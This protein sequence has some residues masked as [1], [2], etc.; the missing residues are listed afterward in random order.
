[1]SEKGDRMSRPGA[2]DNAAP[3]PYVV[4]TPAHNESA[5]IPGLIDCL[6]SQSWR[7]LRWLIVDDASTDGTADLVR[8]AQTRSPWIELL[9]LRR[10]GDRHFGGK[11]L[12]F[13]A[14]MEALRHLPYA[15]IA[16]LDADVTFPPDYFA[17]LR[18][19]LE[20]DP[21]LGLVG[22]PFSEDG[23]EMYDYRFT[24][25]DHVSGACQLF[26]RRCLEEMGGYTPIPGG[27]VDWVASTTA[28][29]LGWKTRTCHDRVLIHHRRMGTGNRGWGNLQLRQGRK[30]YLLGNEPLWQLVRC[31]YQAGRRPYVVGALLMMLGYT[32]NA[33]L[34]KPRPI[35]DRL[36][37]FVREEHRARLRQTA[38]RLLGGS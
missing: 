9:E 35:S 33:V 36:V 20:S 14:G 6:A 7:P 11:A 24:N 22:T 17:Y 10:E 27:G 18:G 5:T 16:N 29:M 32:E 8:A 12:G 3:R 21:R 25:P 26:R 34:R 1:M 23:T 38:R 30:D 4:I 31:L 37:R 28:R 2:D 13:N 15:Y 19:C